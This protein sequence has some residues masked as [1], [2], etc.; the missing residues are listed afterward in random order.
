MTFGPK[1]LMVLPTIGFWLALGFWIN[2]RRP[3]E[4]YGPMLATEFL[5]LLSIIALIV[6]LVCA[7]FGKAQIRRDWWLIVGINVS[8]WIVGLVFMIVH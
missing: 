6:S 8:S 5:L 4:N 1:Y 2:D 3:G 7:I